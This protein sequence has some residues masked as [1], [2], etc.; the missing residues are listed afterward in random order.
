MAIYG[1]NPLDEY[2]VILMDLVNGACMLGYSCRHPSTWSWFGNFAT[3]LLVSPCMESPYSRWKNSNNPYKKSLNKC[4]ACFWLV[5]FYR[6]EVS[7]I[8]GPSIVEKRH[9]L[10]ADQLRTEM[11]MTSPGLVKHPHRCFSH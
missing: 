6:A 7:G 9:W 8:K 5:D 3:M 2:A 11:F 10:S 4:A 1:Y